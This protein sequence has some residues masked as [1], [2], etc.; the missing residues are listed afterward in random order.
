[1]RVVHVMKPG[2]AENGPETLFDAVQ[3]QEIAIDKDA[4]ELDGFVP[5]SDSF[6]GRR[7]RARM[8]GRRRHRDFRGTL[9]LLSRVCNVVSTTSV[10]EDLAACRQL[11]VSSRHRV[12]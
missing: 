3:R 4:S 12:L 6:G 1:M 8:E 10:R 9:L 11:G 7:E 2:L 5:A